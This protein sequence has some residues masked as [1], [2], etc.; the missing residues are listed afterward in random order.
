MRQIILASGSPRRRELLTMMGLDFMVVPSDFDEWLDDAQTPRDV[1][2]QLGLGKARAVASS[3]PDA[4]VIGGDTIVT[5][6]GRQLGK[7]TTVDEARQMLRR[8]A[9]KVHTVTSSAV[10]VCAAEHYEFAAADETLVYFKPYDEAAVETY[11]STNDWRDKAAAYGIQ[12]GAGPLIDHTEGDIE[13]IIGLSTTL[14]VEPLGRFG[15]V[16]KRAGYRLSH[17]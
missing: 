1:A 6:D 5:I 4:I 8:L 17:Q 7:A 11:L 12:S 15:Y 14:L 9:G 10:V 13:T 3:H 16:V 2:I